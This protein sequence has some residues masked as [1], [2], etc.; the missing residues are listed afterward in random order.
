LGE[1]VVIGRPDKNSD[2]QIALIE[3]DKALQRVMTAVLKDDTALF[4]QFKVK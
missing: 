4:K 2:W 1:F 3:H